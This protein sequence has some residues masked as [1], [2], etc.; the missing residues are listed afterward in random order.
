MSLTLQLLADVNLA[1]MEFSDDGRILT[2]SFLNMA[3]GHLCARLLARKVIAFNYHNV[4]TEDDDALPAYIAEV[5]WRELRRNEGAAILR[6]LG[7]GFLAKGVETFT[8]ES[9]FQIHV[10][11]GEIVVDVICGE[12][13]LDHGD[14]ISMGVNE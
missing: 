10:E 9:C 12:Y 1:K 8:P 14:K 11:G 7:Y 5:T 13:S 2:L 6:R 3:D 4:F